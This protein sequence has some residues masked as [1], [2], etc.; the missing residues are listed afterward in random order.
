[1]TAPVG[2]ADDTDVVLEGGSTLVL[3]EYGELK[4]EV[5]NPLPSRRASPAAGAAGRP[6]W[7]SCSSAGT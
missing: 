4:F 2:M 7:S 1:M 5:A 3:D 6:A